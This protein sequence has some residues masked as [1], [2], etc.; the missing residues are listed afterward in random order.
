MYQKINFSELKEIEKQVLKG[1]SLKDSE[2]VVKKA[3]AF[4]IGFSG[5]K[6]VCSAIVFDFETLEIVEEKSKVSEELMPYSPNLIAFREGPAII[7]LYRELENKPD[8]LIVDGH[9]ALHPNKVGVASYVG[10]LL[11]KPTIGVSKELVYGNLDEDKIMF[12][13][14][15]KGYA[16]KAKEF[17]NPVYITA[18]HGLSI[19]KSVE[20]VKKTVVPEFKLPLPMHLA[21]KMTNRIKNDINIK[22]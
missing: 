22:K 11:N 12:N 4:D 18:G 7:D 6:V 1:I 17:A 3:A 2:I 9:G 21:H 13:N 16:I 19:D 5:N 15:I 8:I 14:E 10:V 20:I